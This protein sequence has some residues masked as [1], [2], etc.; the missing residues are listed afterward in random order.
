MARYFS[1]Q[2]DALNE[3]VVFP[4]Q[5]AEMTITTTTSAAWNGT[6]DFEGSTKE[7]PGSTDWFSLQAMNKPANVLART[8]TTANTA[9][10]WT[11]ELTGLTF[12]RV[13]ISVYVAGT[14]DAEALTT[15][16]S[17][18]VHLQYPLPAG[19]AVIGRLKGNAVAVAHG[20]NPTAVAAAANAELKANRAGVPF[21]IG[22]HPN[23]QTYAQNFTSAQTDTALVTV[24]AGTKVVVTGFLVTCHNANTVNTSARL[25]F[26][27]ANVPAYGS[28][29]I[30]GSHPGIAP[31]SGF[32]RGGGAGIVGG[33][34]DDADL[35]FTCSAPTTGSIDVN[36]SYF[37]IES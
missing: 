1:Q 10:F 7:A 34:A 4:A 18:S 11:V 25:G 13:K 15:D 35:R 17:T 30:I 6:F 19:D 3:T 23:I 12:V 28:A 22:G 37:T 36:V 5:G 14:L 33:G 27:T 9:K 31:G 26:G 8:D 20:A 16:V 21:V 2:I 29:G 32:G 24:S